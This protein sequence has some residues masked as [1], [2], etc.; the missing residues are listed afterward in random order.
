MGVTDEPARIAK[1]VGEFRDP[2]NVAAAFAAL[3]AD[4]NDYLGRFTVETPDPVVNAMLNVWNPIQCRTTLFW[5]RF[6]SA[7]ETGTGRGMGTRDSAQDTLGTVHNAAERARST[8]NMLWHLQYQDGHTWHQVLPLTG[9]GGPG[10]RPNSRSGRSGS[11]TI[12]CGSSWACA[13]TCARPATSP[14]STTRSPIGTAARHHLESHA[15]RGGIHPAAPR[16]AGT[17]P[18]R[19]LRL[20]RHDERGSWQRQGRER[21]GRAALLPGHAGSGRTVGSP[22][23]HRPTPSAS[24]ACTPRWRRSSTRWP[25]TGNGTRAPT[26][27][28]A[29]RSA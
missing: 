1:V 15:A 8:L 26:T 24:A 17:A 20:G 9:E 3:N 12:T 14:I 23:R 13:P 6:V 22:R 18:H 11:P 27:T 29:S 4:W 25:G 16:A 5:S 7:Y 21:V 28:K 10:W 19:L 2:K